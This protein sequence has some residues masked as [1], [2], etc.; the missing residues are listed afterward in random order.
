[1]K[2]IGDRMEEMYEALC[3]VLLIDKTDSIYKKLQNLKIFYDF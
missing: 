2:K 3:N 1:M